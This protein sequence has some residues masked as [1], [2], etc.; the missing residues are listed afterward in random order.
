LRELI[1]L[2]IRAEVAGTVEKSIAQYDPRTYG[3]RDLLT[4]LAGGLA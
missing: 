2:L 4:L 3:L 1:E